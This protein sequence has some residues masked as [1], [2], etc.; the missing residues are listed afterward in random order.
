M[1][2][3]FTYNDAVSALT[4]ALAFGIDPS[5]EPVRSMC[6]A[7]GDPQHAFKCMQVA[8]SN[9]KT[10]TSRMIAALMNACGHKTGLYT[11][12]HLVKYPE[13]IEI[14]GIVVDDRF[15]AQ[16][17]SRAY[18]A[19]QDCGIEATEFELLTVA[20]LWLFAHERVE[21]AVLECGLGGRWDATSVVDPQVAVVTGVALEHTAV[22]GDTLE[23]IAA[24]KAAIIK[25]G[26]Q[27]VLA[28]G[29]PAAEVFEARAREV[30]A[31]F[32]YADP[33]AAAP[34][35]DEL[36]HLPGYQRMNFATALLAVTR[37]FDAEPLPETVRAALSAFSVPGRFET[38][39]EEPLLVVDAA[40]NPQSAQVLAL[41][42]KRR[43]AISRRAVPV[44]E[45]ESQIGKPPIPALLLG[46]LA[47]KDV[48]GVVEA[49]CPLF[50]T[51]VVT[52][53]P[54][55]R[56]ISAPQLARIVREVT[57]RDP[58]VAASVREALA[59]L[60]NEPVVATGSITI[61]GEVKRLFAE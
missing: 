26:G 5:L 3:T 17:V 39:R 4:H 48:R 60:E 29:L 56:A 54:S 25:P 16:A 50:D 15:F 7:L 55:P 45:A 28:Y 10:S 9:G 14:G 47:D 57:G 49:L 24:E 35:E 53:S 1:P 41:E 46:V 19:A 32:T 13:R 51:T 52:E 44:T 30:G 2:T 21:W 58:Q 37:A 22:L 27:A 61:A 36:A 59:L 8:G 20:A 42:L 38:L 34:Y 12:P 31:P 11:S 33:N 18:D 43:F 23:E 40:H 6:S